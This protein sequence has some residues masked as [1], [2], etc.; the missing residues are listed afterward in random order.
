[1]KN[2]QTQKN[3]PKGWEEK[4]FDRCVVLLTKIEGVKKSDYNNFGKYPVFDQGQDYISG[5]TNDKNFLNDGKLPVILFGDHTRVFKLINEPFV[6]GNDGIKLFLGNDNIDTNYLYFYLL[7][8]N[9]P[10]TG[11]NR[12]FKFLKESDVLFP[13]DIKEQKRIAEILGEVDKEIE[14]TN[15]IIEKTE[16]LKKG[17]MILITSS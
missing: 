10:N 14:K 13:K 16:K 7:N 5:Y 9:V 3:I 8:I 17:L 12:H 1:M 4:S 6:V 2:N 11:Y 15:E